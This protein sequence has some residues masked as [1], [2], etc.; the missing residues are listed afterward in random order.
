[1]L[2]DPVGEL[3][4]DVIPVSVRFQDGAFSPV[5]DLVVVGLTP[6]GA[7]RRVS[8][9]VRRAPKITASDAATADLLVSYLRVVVEHRDAVRLG[10]WRLALAVASPN[11]AVRQVRELAVI[12][13]G[14]PDEAAFRAAVALP[15]RVGKPARD[16]LGHLDALVAKAA[17]GI[18]TSPAQTDG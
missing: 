5:D 8:I 10:R 12:A 14:Q 13:R 1:V 15:G 7:E 11:P 17:K 3:G 16:R 18:Q 9:G 4:D 6:N 2:G